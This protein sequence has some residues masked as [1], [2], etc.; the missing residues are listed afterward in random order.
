[1][2]QTTPIE[3]AKNC[4]ERAKALSAVCI[5][6]RFFAAG[7]SDSEPDDD[8]EQEDQQASDEDAADQGPALKGARLGFESSSEED[9]KRVVRTEKEKRWDLIQGTIRMLKNHMKINDWQSIVNDFDLV[10]KQLA[11]AKNVVA[12]EGI[13]KFYF[14]AMLELEDFANESF[15][16]MKA[17]KSEK[18][19]KKFNALNAKAL[20]TMKQVSA[21][22]Q[23]D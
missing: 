4:A 12:K 1:M 14:K 10:N 22:R 21:G 16:S 7:G 20:S 3:D 9:E 13:P 5:M 2:G 15:V 6:S 11:Q 19:G 17:E 8:Q 18:G 23:H